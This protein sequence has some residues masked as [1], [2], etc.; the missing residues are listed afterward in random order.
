MNLYL[1]KPI[2][3]ENGPWKPWYDKAFGFVIRA[4]TEEAARNLAD[5]RAGDE[6]SPVDSYG[7]YIYTED[8]PDRHPWLD[9]AVSTCVI[10]TNDGP[11]E[12]IMRDFASA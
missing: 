5:S 11:E 10:L 2:D 6:N 7:N 4:E 8:T 1:L 3:A 12:E 9:P